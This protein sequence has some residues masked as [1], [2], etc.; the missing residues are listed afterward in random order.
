MRHIPL[1]SLL[2]LGLA[3]CAALQ[4]EGNGP[5]TGPSAP[6]P[7]TEFAPAVTTT[8]LGA[9]AVSADALDSTTA[10]EK[11][12]ALAAPAAGGERA[13]GKV[14]VALGPPAEQGIWLS[15][16]LVDKLVQGRIETSAGKSLTLE[17][18]PGSGG[19]L[20]SLAAFQALGLS[21][22]DLPEVTV[23]AR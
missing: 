7:A 2:V 9:Q 17:L 8:A 6:Q 18:R 21:L 20:L 1:I 4:G 3:G 23:Y 11:A 5:V 16:T 15:T 19:A 14:V 10:E 12:A 22:T 13:L